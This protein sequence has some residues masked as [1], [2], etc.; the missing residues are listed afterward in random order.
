MQNLRRLNIVLICCLLILFS[1]KLSA[2]LSYSFR[3][4]TVRDGLPSSYLYGVEQDKNGFLWIAS[5]G[6]I[7][8]FDGKTFEKDPIKAFGSR[9]VIRMVM[10]KQNK[11]WLF[12]LANHI[13][14]YDEDTLINLTA[15]SSYK[16]KVFND[17]FIDPKGNYWLSGTLED[18]IFFIKD[19][20]LNDSTIIRYN[21]SISG[22]K[23]F[24]A[25]N[26]SLEI[27]LSG[28]QAILFRKLRMDSKITMRKPLGLG[29]YHTAK[30]RDTIL[31]ADHTRLYQFDP[32]SISI[33]NIFE[34][35][36][37]NLDIGITCLF[38]DRADNLWIGT[39]EGL[40]LKT[41]K[42]RSKTSLLLKGVFISEITQ[43]HEG[44]YWIA[45]QKDGLFFL[46]SLDIKTYKN[47]NL[48]NHT[49]AVTINSKGEIIIGFDNA[50][51]NILDKNFKLL[52]NWKVP[53]K[54][55]EIYDIHV[56]SLDNLYLFCSKN[57]IYMDANYEKI[58]QKA[59]AYKIGHII[60]PGE[61][62]YGSHSSYAYYNFL[63]DSLNSYIDNK[64][65]ALCYVD[66]NETWV[67]TLE[68]LYHQK[69]GQVKKID[70]PQLNQDIRDIQITPDS[71]LWLATQG[72]G[73]ILYKNDSIYHHFTVENGLLSNN[74]N[75]ILIDKN[76]AWLATN[77]G[78][79][80]I[81][82]PEL[83]LT[84]ITIDNGLPSNEV[85]Y[86]YKKNNK[87]FACTNGGLAVF[88]DTISTTEMPPFLEIAGLS[89]EG[90]KRSLQDA[91]E[92]TYRE[93]NIQ[94][95]FGGITFRHTKSLEYEYIMLG[96]FEEPISTTV[97][98]AQFPALDPG[99]Y[100]FKIKAR[101]KNSNWSAEKTIQFN[102]AKPYWQEWW[103]RLLVFCLT[104]FIILVS[105]RFL[106][107]DIQRRNEVKEKLK[108]SQLTAL[109]AQMNPHFLFN[110]LN[111][112]QE[113]IIN[114]D[115]RSANRYLSKFS[116]LMRNILNMSALEEVDL[117]KEIESLDLYLSLEA[118][119]FEENFE[120]KIELDPNVDS[121]LTMIPPMVVQPY[122]ENAVKHGLLHKTGPKKLTVRFRMEKD[123]LVCE[124]VDNGIGRKKSEEIKKRESHLYS[125]KAMSLTQERL[126]LLNSTHK[127][128][129][130]VEIIDLKDLM[131]IP[132]G[133][134]VILRISLK[135]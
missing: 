82:L 73:L 75:K 31:V 13:N 56:D 43:D 68:G 6:G 110:S 64:T 67:G 3:Q 47:P 46:P 24:V 48:V 74:C 80:K 52:E 128:Q 54:D 49:S 124:V 127:N 106:I 72:D 70:I 41:I 19:S 100:I 1:G 79:H 60:A 36:N 89:I 9:E 65:Y 132:I 97:T 22:P 12:D 21:A 98:E 134:K 40:I 77:K 66:E 115:K 85:N 42:N 37:A 114:Q 129:L 119:R 76:Y 20:Y 28:D 93:N 104:L 34:E 51:I 33:S 25:I 39:Q 111:S 10:D 69:N 53:P 4:Y 102:I 130:S 50:Y 94:I 26:D 83:K 59:G 105:F 101:T 87:I 96:M 116:R 63:T 126:D 122:V 29:A 84:N 95:E 32:D 108:S 107:K 88:Y 133:T 45:T 118:L 23:I 17:L 57:A 91:Y 117:Q 113:F 8:K 44:N 120:Y 90:E 135:K 30:I 14:V 123:F 27:L 55:N 2:Q 11:L 112:I 103:F 86:F 7:C 131:Q 125:S 18:E 62:Q 121:E 78:I 5:E 15:K 109:R 38:S 35:L 71:M 92:L 99:T 16:N 81:S 61:I 58:A